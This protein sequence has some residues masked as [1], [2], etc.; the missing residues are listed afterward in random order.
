V[1][2]WGVVFQWGGGLYGGGRGKHITGQ[3]VNRNRPTVL[4]YQ[5]CSLSGKSSNIV[6]YITEMCM[7]KISQFFKMNKMEGGGG[8]GW[9]L[10]H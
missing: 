10:N 9:L 1:G 2:G 8:R 4:L 7:L 5:A 3:C 6:Y